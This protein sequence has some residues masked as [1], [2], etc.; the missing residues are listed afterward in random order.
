MK[1][2]NKNNVKLKNIIGIIDEPTYTDLLYEIVHYLDNIKKYDGIF[3]I[4]DISLVTKCRINSE[5]IDDIN[6]LIALGYVE[7]I[8]KNTFKI[9]KHKWE[10]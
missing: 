9:I 2:I 3:K 5:L 8:N 1:S 6:E 7:Q 10:S 4:K